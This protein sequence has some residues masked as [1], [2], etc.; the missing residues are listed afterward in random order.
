MS[1]YSEDIYCPK[2]PPLYSKRGERRGI[3][4]ELVEDNYSGTSTD[5]V[6]CPECCSKFSVSYKVDK[7]EEIDP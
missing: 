1:F 5:I 6:Y 7:I 3:H 4:V 2:C